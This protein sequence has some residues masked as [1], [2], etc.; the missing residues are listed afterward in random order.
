MLAACFTSQTTTIDPTPTIF[1][2]QSQVG[3]PTGYITPTECTE[4]KERKPE[5]GYHNRKLG[6]Y[7]SHL[8]APSQ[9][10]PNRKIRNRT[11]FTYDRAFPADSLWGTLHL[12]PLWLILAFTLWI[13]LIWGTFP[14]TATFS[15]TWS[16]RSQTHQPFRGTNFPSW[17]STR[18]QDTDMPQVVLPKVSWPKWTGVG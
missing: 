6:P 5:A 12:L 3:Y 2:Y 13:I 11:P 10:P 8:N 17:T 15:S 4:L 7:T 14:L 18:R 9:S 1:I 16:V